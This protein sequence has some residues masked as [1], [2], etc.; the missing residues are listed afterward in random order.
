MNAPYY[1]SIS[2][3]RVQI[4]L[5]SSLNISRY[6]YS[7]K[8]VWAVFYRCA[9]GRKYFRFPK[10]IIKKKTNKNSTSKLEAE[11]LSEYA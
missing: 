9:D 3:S 2:L 4:T 10:K 1:N 7:G 8:P 5:K 11:L 6:L